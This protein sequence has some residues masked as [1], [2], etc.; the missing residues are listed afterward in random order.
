MEQNLQLLAILA[1]IDGDRRIK[2]MSCL[3]AFEKI[4]DGSAC[5]EK[6]CFECFKLMI[7]EWLQQNRTCKIP[8]KNC[9][10]SVQCPYPK[11]LEELE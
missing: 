7:K 11:L 6:H 1:V 2:E 3:E 9:F 8:C 5:I 10:L 4:C